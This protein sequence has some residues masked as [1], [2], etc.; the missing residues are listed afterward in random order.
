MT[1]IK[2]Q[3]F[4]IRVLIRKVGKSVKIKKATFHRDADRGTDYVTYDDTISTRALVTNVSGW[5]EINY[6]F[7][8]AFEGD[9]LM[10]FNKTESI[11]IHDRIIYKDTEHKITERHDR[12]DFL[13]VVV[14]HV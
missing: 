4:Q 13:E 1:N 9:Y 2:D 11:D 12:E 3:S 5:R 14:E 6:P 7:G 10:M 8:R